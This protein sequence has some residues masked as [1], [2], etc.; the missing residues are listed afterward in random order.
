MELQKNRNLTRGEGTDSDSENE[1]NVLSDIG[2][3][4]KKESSDDNQKVA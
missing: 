4:S 3:S 1:K 2:V